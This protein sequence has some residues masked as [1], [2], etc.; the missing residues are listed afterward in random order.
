MDYITTI[1]TAS[2]YLD[3]TCAAGGTLDVDLESF[4]MVLMPDEASE[5]GDL[6]IWRDLEVYNSITATSADMTIHSLDIASAN[7]GTG[8]AGISPL[9]AI[10]GDRPTMINLGQGGNIVLT[11]GE[12]SH[13]SVSG[14]PP[15]S[16]GYGGDMLFT[17]GNGGVALNA[18]YP[19]GDVE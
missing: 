1:S 5:V 17:A 9:T 2:P 14:S 4:K 16:G 12:G 7:S 18:S 3:A 11:T 10:G 6:I 15:Y 13:M 19:A 8:T